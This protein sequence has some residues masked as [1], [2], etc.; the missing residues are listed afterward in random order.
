MRTRKAFYNNM[1]SGI[2]QLITLI[3]GLII[4]RL[5]IQTYGSEM[6]GL[7]SSTKQLVS[8]LSYLELGISAALIYTLYEPLALKQVNKINSLVTRA[9]NEYKK[10]SIGYLVGVIILSLIYPLF[11]KNSLDYYFVFFIVFITGIYGVFDFYSMAKY[12]V[13][14]TADQKV[15]IV[16]LTS[17]LT[18]LLQFLFSL[19]FI[20]MAQSIIFIIAIPIVVLPL[21]S[22]ILRMYISKN[23]KEINYNYPADN[24]KLETRVDAF[25]SG[26][27]DSLNLSLPIVI[28]S[29]FVSLEMASVFSIY[30]MIFMGI[31]GIVSIFTTGMSASFGNVM[32]KKEDMTLINANDDF[33]F[34]LYLLLSIL[35]SSAMV[36]TIPFIKVYMKDIT[37]TNYI[38]PIYSILFTI[39][40]VLHNSRL[41]N[42]TMI[43]ASGKWKMTTKINIIQII[44]LILGS[45]VFGYFY[46]IVGI[47]ICMS[48]TALYK[49]MAIMFLSNKYIV[50]IN[51]NKS[52]SRLIRIF[53]IVFIVNLPF[54]INFIEIKTTSFFN[55]TIYAVIITVWATFVTIFINLLFDFKSFKNIF[56]RI[57]IKK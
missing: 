39:W 49:T 48:V 20:Y 41:P 56:K 1:S 47:L 55:W 27:S 46:G 37:D 16:T 7:V 18:I 24:I 13:L 30:S 44:L 6:N 43:N 25:V 50:K 31:S 35:Y 23:Y 38:Y 52:L 57:G 8:Y 26:L 19:L 9:K 3:I 21:R 54:L 36:L 17:I 40:G 45:I 28:V 2:Q 33:E 42:H 5:L 53:T 4:P 29:L 22:L 15:N 12:R 34:I 10:I 14:L 11:L 51:N 32:A